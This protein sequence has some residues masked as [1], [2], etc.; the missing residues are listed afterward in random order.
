MECAACAGSIEKSIKRLPGIEEATVAVLQNRA[1]VIYRPAFVLQSTILESISD[2]GFEA[3]IVFD[4][5]VQSTKTTTSRFRIKGMT[6]TSCSTSIESSLR[7]LP[8]VQSAN[9]ALAT[10]ECEV[11]HDAGVLSREEIVSFIDELGYDAEV[12]SFEE[13]VNRV[14]LLL[15][16]VTD[17]QLVEEVLNAVNGVRSVFVDP[18]GG[19][20]TVEY[21]PEKAGPRTL[22]KMGYDIFRNFSCVWAWTVNFKGLGI[23]TCFSS[24]ENASFVTENGISNSF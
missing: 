19:T 24:C 10:E 2:A 8:G 20:A 16:D 11:R 4:E 12:L 23:A 14:R 15:E 7:K 13:E 22:L 3:S 6:C 9:V 5:L 1:Q 21:D 17:F 18:V